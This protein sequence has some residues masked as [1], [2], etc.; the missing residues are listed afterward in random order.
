MPE[1]E[2]LVLSQIYQ[3][4]VVSQRQLTEKTN[5]SLGSVNIILNRLIT[6]GWIK[7]EKVSARQLR[8][9]LTPQGIA[10]CT[11][12]TVAFV[13]HAYRQIQ[14]LQQALTA[15]HQEHPGNTLV[16]YGDNDEIYQILIQAASEH[17]LDVICVRDCKEIDKTNHP[18]AI[19]WQEKQERD[20]QSARI[21][22]IHIIRQLDPTA[23]I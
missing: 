17:K 16:L 8:Y 7:I 1:S 4:D 13:K 15:I 11:R 12:K 9:I 2:D 10:R 21:P 6:R 22:V 18:I 19:V 20:C 5:L 3:N 14:F 23:V